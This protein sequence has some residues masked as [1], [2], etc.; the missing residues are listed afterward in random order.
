[1]FKNEKVD[2]INER[3]QTLEAKREEIANTIGEMET[4]LEQ[5][6]EMFALGQIEEK[7]INEAHDFLKERR[8]E[9]SDI[10]RMVARVESVRSKVKV[11][12]VPLVREWRNKQAEA[13]QKDVDKAVKEA[14]AAREAFVKALAKVGQ[15]Q[16]KINA[17]NAEYNDLMESLGERKTS[18]QI[19]VP[20]VYPETITVGLYAS[21]VKED[22]AIGLSKATQEAAAKRGV[23]PHWVGDS[24]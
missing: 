14:L 23:L 13:V 7:D 12:S 1:M 22:T 4:A 2:K 10:E 9:L 20:S 5:T 19:N 17:P 16:S 15:A 18:V 21:E 8:A 3:L 24:K 6:V 11:E